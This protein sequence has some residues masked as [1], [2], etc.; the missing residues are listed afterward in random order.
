MLFYSRGWMVINTNTER[1]QEEV[2]STVSS[3]LDKHSSNVDHVKEEK[4]WIFKV[5]NKN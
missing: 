4:L 2:K 3:L 5:S 1:V